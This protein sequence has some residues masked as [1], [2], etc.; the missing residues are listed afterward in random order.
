MVFAKSTKVGIN[1]SGISTTNAERPPSSFKT[2]NKLKLPPKNH[3]VLVK[4]S[5]HK[6]LPNLLVNASFLEE[7][8]NSVILTTSKVENTE[9]VSMIVEG[10]GF[11]DV[12]IRGLS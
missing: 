5:M 6:S 2:E 1:F 3:E 7:L 9:A 8:N 12:L 11:E 4:D 10:L